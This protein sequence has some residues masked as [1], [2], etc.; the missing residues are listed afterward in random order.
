MEEL[1]GKPLDQPPEMNGILYTSDYESF[2]IM[3]DL[4]HPLFEF[5]G[6]NLASKCLSGDHVSFHEKCVLELRDEHPLIVGTIELSNPTQYGRTS[7]GIPLYLFRPYDKKYP[8]FVV[9][10]SEKDKLNRIGLIQFGEWKD[11][12]PRGHLQRIIGYSGE[13]EAE[14]EAI[15]WQTCPYIYSKQINSQPVQIHK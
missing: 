14:K 6:A 2:Q 13:I 3:D 8:F 11:H 4:G 7:R 5:E 10:C 15:L 9:G 12:L 1:W